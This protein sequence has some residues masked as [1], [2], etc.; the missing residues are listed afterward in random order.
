MLIRISTVLVLLISTTYCLAQDAKFYAQTD[1]QQIIAGNYFEVTFTLEN[2]KGDSFKAPDFSSFEVLSGPSRS[3][4]M[5]IINGQ[6][7]QKM[8]YGYGLTAMKPGKYTIGAA[9]I[10]ANGQS[11]STKPIS[12]EVMASSTKKSN[13][14]ASA[15]SLTSADIFVEA[16]LDR[17]TAHIGQQLTLK[18][19]LYTT[20]DVRSVNFAQAPEF[21]G[22]FAQEIQNYRERSQ[23]VI[24]NGIQYV[25]R[26]VKVIALFP[27]QKGA[28][29]IGPAK[30]NLGISTKT[31]RSSFFFNSNLK[32]VRVNS[33][34]FNIL[35]TDLPDQAPASFAG[36]IGDFYLGTAIDKNRLSM[37]DALTL[38]YQ[39][40]GDGDGKLLTAPDQPLGD[41]FDIYEPNLLREENNVK[42]GK[43]ITT[44]T[45][46]YLMIPKKEG[47]ISFNPELSFFDLDSREFKTI[48]G[49]TYTVSVTPS[50]GRQ[51]IDLD[52][53]KVELPNPITTTTLKRKNTFFFQSVPYWI[54]NG[55]LGL[56]FIGLLI[57]KKIQI[58]KDDIDPAELKNARAK[59]LAIAQ[60][61]EAKAA[62]SSG[63]TK[64]FYIL[65]RKGLLEF[66]A[67]KTFQSSAQMSKEDISDLL[68]SSDLTIYEADIL[69]IM[70]KGEMA[71]Y[72]NMTPGN[73]EES[74]ENTVRIIQNIETSLKK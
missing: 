23:R 74:Y 69:D 71:I 7:S 45:F 1:A 60:L 14:G 54:A 17:D 32:T 43:I 39:I 46:E 2:L 25:S 44:K 40:K 42:D 61:S 41:L 28:F 15:Q 22:F 31:G 19:V 47:V 59:K 16:Q 62:W 27:Q 67:S 8:S 66:L 29:E 24:K 48:K 10:R 21:D 49:E 68:S 58:N 35:V 11:F 64:Q 9:T 73:E 51:T 55:T 33:D 56:A 50:T 13:Q 36:A 20:K 6:T 12:I 65:L 4:Q 18:Y 72:A 3:T 57:A 70:Q 26:A 30:I 52:T 34:G 38:T 37:D 5:S 53:R 63:H